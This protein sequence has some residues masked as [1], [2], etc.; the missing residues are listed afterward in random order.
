MF[1]FFLFSLFSPGD[2]FSWGVGFGFEIRFSSSF[3]ESG[4]IFW[5]SLIKSTVWLLM[6]WTSTCF[7]H[8]LKSKLSSESVDSSSEEDVML[9]KVTHELETP[10]SSTHLLSVPKLSHKLYYLHD[11]IH[12]GFFLTPRVACVTRAVL[13]FNLIPSANILSSR[14]CRSCEAILLPRTRLLPLTP[15]LTIPR[16]PFHRLGDLRAN[17]LRN[18]YFTLGFMFSEQD[19]KIVESH[20]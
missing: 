8:I 1:G 7:L 20:K 18:K 19:L 12:A 4:S 13:T 11:S 9:G 5:F 17:S 10:C 16:W 6:C 14:A 3:C 15:R 2:F